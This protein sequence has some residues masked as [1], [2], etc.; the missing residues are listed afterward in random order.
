ML[1][2]AH[3]FWFRAAIGPVQHGK[4]ARRRGRR[5]LGCEVLESRHLL[6]F[7]AAFDDTA[8]FMLGQVYVNVVFMESNTALVPHDTETENWTPQLIADAKTKVAAGVQWWQD[9][10]AARFPTMGNLLH[11][12]LDYTH[13]DSPVQT[14]YE[15]IQ[16][17]SDAVQNWIVDFE[18]AVNFNRSSDFH[19]NLKAYNDAQRKSHSSDWSFTVFVV[20]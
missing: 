20:N 15:P 1:S 13:A 2:L 16:R 12:T 5:R 14:G 3:K 8:E 19:A 18:N 11:F 9:T 6:A 10:L 7:G 4:V 17:K